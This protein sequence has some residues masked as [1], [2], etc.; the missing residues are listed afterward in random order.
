[1]PEK[2]APPV[3]EKSVPVAPN[4]QVA[5]EDPVHEDLGTTTIQGVEARGER[6]TARIPVGEAGNDKPIA[7]MTEVW[8]SAG[9]PVALRE[10]NTD[11]RVGKRTREVVRFTA[12]EP[13]LT[14]F[15]PPDGYE[16]V[17]EEMREISCRD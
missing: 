14:L 4:R 3:I 11:P 9:F 6:W 17:T 10:I 12:G 16:I 8:Q 13:D 7:T 2:A 15:Q 5:R 1:V